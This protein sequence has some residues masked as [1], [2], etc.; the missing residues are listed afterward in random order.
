[1]FHL[2]LGS[3]RVSIF[4]AIIRKYILLSVV[5]LSHDTSASLSL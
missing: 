1:M 5:N 3:E 2:G 4:V